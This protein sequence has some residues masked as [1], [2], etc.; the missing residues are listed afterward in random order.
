MET[1]TWPG[2][3]AFMRSSAAGAT[4][5][6]LVWLRQCWAALD[7]AGLTGYSSDAD[8][9]RVLLRPCILL[10]ILDEYK[11]LALDTDM[12]VDALELWVLLKDLFVSAGNADLS[13]EWSMVVNTMETHYTQAT[14]LRAWPDEPSLS[15]GVDAFY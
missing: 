7:E 8:L 15:V 12:E 13:A 9:A 5:K 2:L 14:D 6:E 11:S 4:P 3:D 10:E 1:I